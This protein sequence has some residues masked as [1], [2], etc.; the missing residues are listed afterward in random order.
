MGMHGYIH[1]YLYVCMCESSTC[2]RLVKKD[3]PTTSPAALAVKYAKQW[4][5]RP[6]LAQEPAPEHYARASTQAC[7]QALKA[8]SLEGSGDSS[9][10]CTYDAHMMTDKHQNTPREQAVRQLGGSLPPHLS[11]P[12]RSA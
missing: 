12:R 9:D 2:G 3:Y 6:D 4:V 1:T 8:C 11:S 7:K 5:A 10:A